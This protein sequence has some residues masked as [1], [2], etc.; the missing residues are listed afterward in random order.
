M[1]INSLCICPRLVRLY[2]KSGLDR[3]NGRNEDGEP[4]LAFIFCPQER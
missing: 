1:N 2:Q 4:N 3:V